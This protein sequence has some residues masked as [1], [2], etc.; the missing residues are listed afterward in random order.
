MINLSPFVNVRIDAS[1]GDGRKLEELFGIDL[2]SAALFRVLIALV[3]LVDLG[4]RAT[5]LVA[6]YT[7]FGLLPRHALLERFAHPWTFCLHLI[8]GTAPVQAALFTFQALAAI[9]LLVGWQTRWMTFLTWLL[10]MSLQNRNPAVLQGGDVLLRCALFWA[11]FLPLGARYSVD[12]ALDTSARKSPERI[13]TFGTIAFLGQVAM[14]YAFAGVLKTGPEWSGGE[15]VYYAL[16]LESFATDL[17]RWLLHLPSVLPPLTCLVLLLEM[18]A[19]FFLFYPSFTGPARAAV[20]ALY[21][22]F[23]LNLAVFLHVGEFPWVAIAC[24]APFLPSWLWEKASAAFRPADRA[25]LR[26]YYDADCGFCKKSVYLLRTFLLIPEARLIEAQSD[27]A[28]AARMR[29][30]HSWVV[31]NASGRE[32]VRYD[33]MTAILRASPLAPLGSALSTRP[34]AA[35]G[36]RLYGIVSGHR[37]AAARF[38]SWCCFREVR[39]EPG[40]SANVLAVLFLAYVLSWNLGNVPSA[41]WAVPPNLRWIGKFLQLDQ[42][43]SMFAPSPSKQDG[44]YVIPATLRDGTE[45]DLFRGK[46][47]VDWEKPRRIA[48][49]NQRWRKYYS[50]IGS[51]GSMAQHRLYYGKYLCRRWNTTHP[52]E[53]HVLTFSI[54]YMMRETLPGYQAPKMQKIMIWRHSCFDSGTKTLKIE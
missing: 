28:V 20:V 2:R 35:A 39:A 6:H 54:Y 4:I 32:F 27:P 11:M 42:N 5:D 17:G 38:L 14:M 46:G 18:G 45:I 40:A 49:K 50:N 10:V 22:L 51:S 16:S 36:S 26:I 53:K 3:V 15:A 19:P 48:Y 7:D 21:G 23:Q 8:G 1:K 13:L 43:W 31:R 24:L 44:W 30:S 34:I 12:A 25:G 47:P 29:E 37:R 9:L 33:A 52:H 41:K